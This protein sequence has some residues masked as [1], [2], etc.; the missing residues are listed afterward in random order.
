MTAASPSAKPYSPACDR[1]RAPILAVLQPLL[2][3]R[4]RVLEIGSGTGQHAAHFAAALPHLTWQA[5]DRAD[6]L[7]GIRLWLDEA[8]LAN[9]PPPLMLDVADRATWPTGGAPFDALFSANTLHYMPE[10]A[11]ADFFACTDAA[12][13]DDACL[14]VYGPFNIA[15]AYTSASN[16]EFDVWLKGVDPRFAIR[17]RDAVDALAR[18]HGWRLAADH[19]LPANNRCLVWQRG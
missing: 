7:P 11:V 18:P 17:D 12:A 1:N 6:W 16:A 15:G 4:T 10:A 5:S 8:A 19:A 14:A 13:A 3:T 2:A 9:T